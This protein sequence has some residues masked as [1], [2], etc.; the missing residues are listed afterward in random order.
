MKVLKTKQE[1][2]EHLFEKEVGFV[3]TMGAL[4]RGHGRLVEE[5][6]LQNEFTLLSVFVNPT[7]F[8]SAEDFKTYPDRWEQD[9]SFCEDRNV[10]FLF[11]PPVEEVYNLN[12]TISFAEN[13][14]SSVF[15]GEFRP[16]HFS[17]V[18]MVVL[19]LLSIIKPQRAYFGEKDYQQLI[20][21]EQL[22]KNFFLDTEIIGVPT[23]RDSRGLAMSSRNYNLTS[24]GLLKAQKIAACFVSAQSQTEFMEKTEKMKLDLE[25]YGEKWGRALMAHHIDGVRLIDNKPLNGS[26]S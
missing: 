23:L 24:K 18:L 9:F 8:N 16:G 17:G 25:Y 1:V 2:R 6:Q 14:V 12:E 5:S 21:I 20:L 7:Q 3:A 10:D 19:K 15:E 13:D 11:A 26:L 4:H 22:A